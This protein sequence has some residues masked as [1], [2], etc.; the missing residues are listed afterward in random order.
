MLASTEGDG[1][2]VAE[3][4]CLATTRKGKQVL[5]VDEPAEACCCVPANGDMVAVVGETPYAEGN[6]DIPPSGT[7]Q[8]TDRKS[9]V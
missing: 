9:V 4:E 2:V 7:L 1:F 8:H 6:G 5:N 3:E